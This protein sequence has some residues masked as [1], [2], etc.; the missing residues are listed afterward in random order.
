MPA[1]DRT[2]LDSLFDE[3]R[4]RAEITLSLK[5]PESRVEREHRLAME[6]DEARH[7]R[8]KEVIV[9]IAVLLGV[10]IVLALCLWLAAGTNS[11]P[12]DKKWATA[13]LASVVTLGMGYLVGKNQAP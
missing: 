12:E 7:G 11:S 9:L 4:K 3:L 6:A 1:R 13:I 2:D 8:T 5:P 10:G